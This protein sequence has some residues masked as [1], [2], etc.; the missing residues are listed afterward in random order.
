LYRNETGMWTFD[1]SD[2]DNIDIDMEEW[3]T[4]STSSRRRT[5]RVEFLSRSGCVAIRN[6]KLEAINCKTKSNWLCEGTTENTLEPPLAVKK[7]LRADEGAFCLWHA[8][9]QQDVL[10]NDEGNGFSNTDLA[11]DLQ[12]SSSSSPKQCRWNPERFS[13]NGNTNGQLERERGHPKHKTNFPVMGRTIGW[14][15]PK[16]DMEFLTLDNAYDKFH[17]HYTP[18][19]T[20]LTRMYAF[21]H[22]YERNYWGAMR[23]TCGCGYKNIAKLV[24]RCDCT[25]N[26]VRSNNCARWQRE[27]LGVMANWTVRCNNCN[28]KSKI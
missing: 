22:M 7:D 3:R 28:S 18:E 15:G 24:S 27:Q 25:R 10:P 16:A 26:G 20:G 23:R 9:E 8:F 17:C 14:T 21:Q 12:V 13:V 11:C 2:A 1:R 5:D 19:N 6:K 4:K